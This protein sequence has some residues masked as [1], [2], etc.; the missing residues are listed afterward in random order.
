MYTRI[1]NVTGTL[2]I[3]FSPKHKPKINDSENPHHTVTFNECNWTCKTERFVSPEYIPMLLWIN[4]KASKK[5]KRE[6]V[7]S[8]EIMWKK[9][10]HMLNLAGIILEDIL[11][12]FLDSSTKH[13]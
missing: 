10:L 13:S 6:P 12:D 9:F 8:I 5:L 1:D 7:L 2:V 4:L 11:H 3:N